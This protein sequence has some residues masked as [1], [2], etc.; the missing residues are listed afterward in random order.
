M[1]IPL[2]KI[3]IDK[4]WLMLGAAVVL[5]LLAAWLT[6]QYLNYKTSAIEA[7]VSAK[8]KQ[9]K[10]EPVAVV[11]PTGDMPPGT[12]LEDSVVASREVN[13]DFVYEDTIRV[14]DFDNFKGHVLIKPVARGRPLRRQDV[15]E[16]FSDFAGTVPEGKR[17]MTIEI[18]ELNSIA[19][20]VQPGNLVDLMI[21]LSA[22]A[23][24]GGTGSAAGSAGQVVVPFMEKMKVLATGQT[25]TH[26]DQGL[27]GGQTGR[28]VS[29]N[30]LTLEVSPS[31]AARLTLAHELGKVRAVLRNEKDPGEVDFGT[32]NARNL[33]AEIQEKA[34]QRKLAETNSSTVGDS[35]SGYVE[36]IIGGKGGGGISQPMSVPLAEG[37]GGGTAMAP[38]DAGDASAG[39]TVDLNAALNTVQ[40]QIAAQFGGAAPAKPDAK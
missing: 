17:A 31:E 16:I 3:N 5:S 33:L 29:Y 7:E 35:V 36:Y 8:A 23:N 9:S 10:G 13:S 12:L 18:D 4:T 30:N 6:L 1:K 11:V 19:N 39:K 37:I 25:I 24:P 26:E 20:M 22:D 21:V 15:R 34:R 14:A 38:P 27:G 2:P 28:R 32:V 40:K